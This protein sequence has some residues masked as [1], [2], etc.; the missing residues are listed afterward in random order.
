M[1]GGR[2]VGAV[3][4]L[5]TARRCAQGVQQPLARCVSGCQG[6]KGSTHVGAGIAPGALAALAH[7]RA[8]LSAVHVCVKGAPPPALP[9]VEERA[10]APA[11]RGAQ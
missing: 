9:W 5:P 4:S 10:L 11:C 3:A 6:G 2:G 7:C 8:H 1:H